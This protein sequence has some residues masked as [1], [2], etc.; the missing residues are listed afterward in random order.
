M[1][2]RNHNR[3]HQTDTNTHLEELEKLTN[4]LT[5]FSDI[6]EER[7]DK[8]IIMNMERGTCLGFNLLNKPD[9]AAADFFVSNGSVFRVHQHKQLEYIIIYKGKMTINIFDSEELKNIIETHTLEAGECFK[10]EKGALHSHEY[11]EDS[12]VIA[13]TIPREEG[14]PTT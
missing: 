4:K 13:I 12:W 5:R 3:L 2:E 8:Y 9:V 14:F 1:I 10:I 6:V 11:L 7:K